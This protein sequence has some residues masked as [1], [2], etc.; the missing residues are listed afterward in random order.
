LIEMSDVRPV[1]W[2]TETVHNVSYF[3]PEGRAA[4][5]ALGCRGM[6]MGY[7]GTRAA[8]LG[9][10]TAEAVIATF[11]SFSPAMVVHILISETTKAIPAASR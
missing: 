2:L 7:F 1:W 10:V 4:T 5:D 3:A 9:A 8:P 11:V 6:R